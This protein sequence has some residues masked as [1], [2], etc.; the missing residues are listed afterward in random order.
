MS[1]SNPKEWKIG[2]YNISGAQQSPMN[3]K[4]SFYKFN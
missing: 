4:F 1:A 2:I 3:L